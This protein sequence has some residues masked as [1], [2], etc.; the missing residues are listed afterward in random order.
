MEYT[1][2]TEDSGVTSLVMS[3]IPPLASKVSLPDILPNGGKQKTLSFIAPEHTNVNITCAAYRNPD[4][5]QTTALLMIQG[6]I[7]KECSMYSLNHFIYCRS[8]VWCW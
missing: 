7:I 3:T 1:C 4:V 5:N 6:K 2:A 8:L